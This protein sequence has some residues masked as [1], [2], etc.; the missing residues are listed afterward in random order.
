V[1]RLLAS[2]EEALASGE[3]GGRDEALQFV[4]RLHGRAQRQPVVAGA[5][6]CA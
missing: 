2:L 6:G 1:G 3:I 5:G 4:R